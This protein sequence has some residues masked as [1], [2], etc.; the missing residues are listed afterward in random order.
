VRHARALLAEDDRAESQFQ[1]GLSAPQGSSVDRARLQLAYGT[2]LRRQ[3]HVTRSRVP[4]RSARDIF[5]SLGVIPWGDRA[6]QELRASG[7]ASRPH[8]AGALESLT[9]QELQIGMLAADGLS[10]RE[11]G[12][13]LYVSHRTVSTHLSHIF[14][15]LALTSRSELAEALSKRE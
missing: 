10:N 3:R 12:Q 5:D 1:A 6:R 11:I 14:R 9:P 15:K 7:E 13:R 2:W 8:I 4:L